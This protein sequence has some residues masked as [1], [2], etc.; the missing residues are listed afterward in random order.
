MGRFDQ[1]QG[2]LMSAIVHL[3]IMMA[4]INR[5]T[6]REKVKDPVA[7]V[8]PVKE[9]IF[10]PSR[11]LL[12]QLAPPPAHRTPAPAPTPPPVQARPKDRISIGPPST[13]RAKVL[14][15]RREDDLTK[16]PKG[17]PNALP[18]ALPTAAP[19]VA[20]SSPAPV[21][22]TNAPVRQAEGLRLPS[23]LNG[24][25]P[26][27]GG[28]RAGGA[29]P[30]PTLAESLRNLDQRLADVGPRGIE[31][32]TGQ[33][34]GPLFFDPE[35]ADFTVWINHFKNEVYRNW[36]VPQAALLGFR[37]HVDLEFSVERDGT[38]SDLRMLKSSGTPA[39]DRAA[40]NALMGSRL[41]PLPRDFGPPRV[42]M[43]V[44]F[45]YNQGPQG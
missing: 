30:R 10:M 29:S 6:N 8:G 21:P 17:K 43:Q 1:R 12:R 20:A 26:G 42:T 14:E 22:G 35:G 13:D 34:M 9:H 36:I 2:F 15:L 11:E 32:G 27:D 37:G 33:Q 38:L 19:A 45:F 23:G 3:M 4:L 44:T 28:S 5:V 41:L 31:S 18:S 40:A 16:V 24:P 39:L 7:S 25:A